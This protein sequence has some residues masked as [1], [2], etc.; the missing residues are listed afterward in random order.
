MHEI[1]RTAN[2]LAQARTDMALDRTVMALE[3]T[4]MAWIRTAISMISFGFTMFKFLQAFEGS[5]PGKMLHQNAPR[6]LGLML[7]LMGIGSLV[8]G[9]LQYKKAAG[10]LG[11]SSHEKMPISLSMIAAVC[12]LLVGIFTILNMYTGLGGF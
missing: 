3:R 11:K 6:R 9:I 12:V 10:I 7:I 1:K 8:L 2:E 4:L 5:A